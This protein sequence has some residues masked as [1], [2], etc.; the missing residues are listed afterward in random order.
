MKIITQ[1][2]K[3]LVTVIVIG[4]GIALVPSCDIVEEPYL[5]KVK[6]DGG[7]EPEEKVR[8]FLLEDF[9]GQQCPNCPKAAQEAQNLKAIYGEQL[10]VVSIHSGPFSVPDDIYTADFRT[11]EG[12]VMHDF[13]APQGYPV[14]MVNRTKFGNSVM[15]LKDNWQYAVAE[16]ALLDAQ[17][18]ITIENNYNA[19]TRKLDCTVETEFLEELTGTYN[20]C[21]FILES[22]IISPQLTSQGKD[23]DYEHNHMLRG[24]LN[25]AWGDPVGTDGTAVIG[26]TLSDNYSFT[27]PS[28]WVAENCEVIAFVYNA[29]T[30][31]IVQAVEAE[32][33]E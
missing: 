10:I 12:T 19:S 8:K 29:E 3:I 18:W 1:I 2:S 17:A 21:V 6:N 26:N 11:P 13:F 30:L 5:V 32:L 33:A 9:T 4:I 7:T 20:I 14:G 24:T 27:L 22:G 16:Q 28:H 31:E 25:G 15:M 23:E